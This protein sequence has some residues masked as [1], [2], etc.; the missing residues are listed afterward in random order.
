M[1]TANMAKWRDTTC[2]EICYGSAV[3]E[4]EIEE[5]LGQRIRRE[6]LSR[7][8]SQDDLAHKTKLAKNTIFQLETGITH[9]AQ[10][11]SLQRYAEAFEVSVDY[12]RTGVHP[13]PRLDSW[14]EVSMSAFARGKGLKRDEDIKILEAMFERL[15]EVQ[16]VPVGDGDGGGLEG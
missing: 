5:T 6:R 14:D 8:W 11:E 16:D 2:E 3:I 7:G 13:A 4:Q 10:P 15:R 12:L 1:V 9:A